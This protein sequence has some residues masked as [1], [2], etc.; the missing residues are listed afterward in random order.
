MDR[1]DLDELRRYLSELREVL[2]D[3]TS[4]G[5]SQ[6][7]WLGHSHADYAEGLA[8]VQL[9]MH[10]TVLA[11]DRCLATIDAIG[12]AGGFAEYII[13]NLPPPAD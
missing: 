2:A 7:R 4:A 10:A 6:P 3:Y 5:E 11:V 13:A 8:H 12:S 1:P 9:T